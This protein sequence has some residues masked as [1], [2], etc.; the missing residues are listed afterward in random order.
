[1]TKLQKVLI[2]FIPPI[3]LIFEK[4]YTVDSERDGDRTQFT[5]ILDLVTIDKKD[6]LKSVYYQCTRESTGYTVQNTH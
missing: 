4:N 6:V 1:M 5:L 2:T 3:Q